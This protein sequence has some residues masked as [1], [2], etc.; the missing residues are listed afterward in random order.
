MLFTLHSFEV[1][2]SLTESQCFAVHVESMNNKL[3]ATEQVRNSIS[4]AF[5]KFSKFS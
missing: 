3:L 2:T 5:Y 1:V 4:T